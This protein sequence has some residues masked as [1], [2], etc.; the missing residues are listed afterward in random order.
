MIN[1][2]DLYQI[3][4]TFAEQGA[5][6]DKLSYVLSHL[7]NGNG[8]L[9]P[10]I[11]Q[12]I[13][14]VINGLY[15]KE[16]N[17]AQE[18]L[19]W[20]MLQDGYMNVTDCY[21]E[22]HLVTKGQKT[23]VRVNF[24][25]LC[26][27]G[28]M[29]KHGSKSGC[30]RN[31]DKDWHEMDWRTADTQELYLKF[32]MGIEDFARLY[33]KNIIIL[34]GVANAGKTAF[35]LEFARLNKNRFKVRPRYLSSEMG[36]TELKNRILN[37]PQDKHFGLDTWQGVEFIERNHDYQDLITGEER[38]FIID[39]LE[40][41]NE[42]WRTA[43]IINEIYTRLDKGLCIIALQ[44]DPNKQYAWGGQATRHKARLSIVLERGKIILQKVKSFRTEHNPDGMFREFKLV[45]G[46]KFLP[47]G[48]WLQ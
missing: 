10:E 48:E 17:I 16:R 27:K 9:S 31:V 14:A 12:K 21:N 47:Q 1:E 23:A 13:T 28:I 19:D 38:I 34:E 7:K 24:H 39:Y 40:I 35:C 8:D 36:E 25:R 42:V 18:V 2:Q 6:P 26:E 44:R 5:T 37:Y 46:W 29:Q 41:Y 43:E 22:L 30:Y 11:S 33:R 20:T 32:P 45:S 15:V 3:I 4:C